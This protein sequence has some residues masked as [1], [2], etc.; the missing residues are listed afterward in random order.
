MRCGKL[1][2]CADLERRLCD[3][4][5]ERTVAR[6]VLAAKG[7]DGWVGDSRYVEKE[8]A[9]VVGR[10]NGKGMLTAVRFKA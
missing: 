4:S 5:D 2:A 8:N 3:F 6:W 10:V 9:E 7:R 1:A